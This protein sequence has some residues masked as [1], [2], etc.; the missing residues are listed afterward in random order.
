MRANFDEDDPKR[1]WQNQETEISRMSSILL[2]QKAREVQ[3]RRRRQVFASIVA[4]VV[5]AFFYALCVKQFPHLQQILRS[6]F[7]FDLVWSVAGLYFINRKKSSREIPGDAGFSTGLEFCR[8]TIE[9][10]LDHFRRALLWS[11]G[12]ILLAIGTFLV[13]TAVT[14]SIFP[15][16]I[17]FIA[18]V[19]VWI[20][21]Y[22]SIGVRQHRNLRREVDELKQIESG[23]S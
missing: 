5:V 12:P 17:P 1:I 21:S 22:L 8:R 19:L 20:A 23:S 7:L 18:L 14:T 11:F 16:G 6:L 13:T 2:Q 10:Q 9:Q 15:K 4:P 3:A